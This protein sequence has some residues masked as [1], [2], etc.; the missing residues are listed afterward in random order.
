M[1]L[2]R[3]TAF[4]SLL[5]QWVDGL[6]EVHPHTKA[7]QNRTNVHVAFHLYDFLILFGPVISWWCFPFERLIGT[8]Q[9][10]NTNNH[11]GGMIR[12]LSYFY[13]L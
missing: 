6:H 13:L 8:I 1:T 11:I 12:L 9:K 4:R 7:H 3:A 2:A 10:V 5:K